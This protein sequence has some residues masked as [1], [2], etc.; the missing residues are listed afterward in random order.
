MDYLVVALPAEGNGQ[1]HCGRASVQPCIAA[2]S[3]VR[4]LLNPLFLQVF[5]CP[6]EQAQ[7]ITDCTLCGFQNSRSNFYVH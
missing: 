7:S 3:A 2:F 6:R 1:K 5:A 4:P